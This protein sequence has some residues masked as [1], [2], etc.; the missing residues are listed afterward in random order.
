MILLLDSSTYT[1]KLSLID[2]NWRYDDEWQAD[3]QLA[4]GL[5]GYLQGQLSKHDKTLMDVSA[6][7]VF[8]GPGSF[9]GLRI[10]LAVLNTVAASQE[11][12]I[13]GAT[14]DDWQAKALDKINNRQNDQLVLPV[15]GNPAHITKPRK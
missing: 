11:I 3:R 1:C 9:T 14:G 13:V 5:L 2:G 6:I 15:Y 7:G 8:Q 10:G 12:P 4:K